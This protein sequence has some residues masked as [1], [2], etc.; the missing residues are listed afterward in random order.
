[1]CTEEFLG[2]TR[3]QE[4]N[5]SEVL[6]SGDKRRRIFTV[7]GTDNSMRQALIVALT[8]LLLIPLVVHEEGKS[9]QKNLGTIQRIF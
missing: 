1:M 9:G 8:K 2:P 3:K 6:S 5:E 4:S 7:S